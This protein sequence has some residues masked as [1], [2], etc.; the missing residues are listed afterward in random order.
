[1]LHAQYARIA[2]LSHQVKAGK[3]ASEK[4]VQL[5]EKLQLVNAELSRLEGVKDEVVYTYF[6]SVAFV[7]CVHLV[8]MFIL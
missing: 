7:S 8:S 5:E 4:V 1:M 6:C 2:S 3:A